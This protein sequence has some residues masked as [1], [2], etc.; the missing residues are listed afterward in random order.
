MKNN[1]IKII[2][3]FLILALSLHMRAQVYEIPFE[4]DY[5]GKSIYVSVNGNKPVRF[6]FD[7]GSEITALNYAYAQKIGLKGDSIVEV[8]GVTGVQKYPTSK[9]N[10]L[11]LSKECAL[12]NIT[13]T[14]LSLS[15]DTNEN[16]MQ[17][18]IGADILKR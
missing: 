17:G 3:G 2:A 5:T 6:K 4:Y 7:T 16:I 8:I 1:Y 11:H 18:I 10:V 14:Q 13:L 15:D 12:Q 9:N